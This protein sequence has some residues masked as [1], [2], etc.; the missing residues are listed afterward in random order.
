MEA[1]LDAAGGDGVGGV[2]AASVC[3]GEGGMAT[4]LTAAGGAGK[5]WL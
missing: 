3:G 2:E 5:A 1:P 4:P